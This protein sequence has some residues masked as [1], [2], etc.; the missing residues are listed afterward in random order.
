MRT[1]NPLPL[2][3]PPVPSTTKGTDIMNQMLLQQYQ[4][5]PLLKQYISAY[6]EEMD[7]LFEETEKV[8]LGRFL[9]YAEGTQLDIIGYILDEERNIS[10]PTL[11]FGFQDGTN[12]TRPP[13]VE[14]PSFADESAPA[15]GGVFRSEGQSGSENY[16]LSDNE[17]RRLLSAKAIISTSDVCS[18]NQAYYAITVLLGRVPLVMRFLPLTTAR[19]VELELD[20]NDTTAADEALIL[21][22]SKY[23]I[24]LGTTIQISRI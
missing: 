2:T 11:F 24:P 23:I 4:N 17:F 7:L 10:L 9:Q 16:A 13:N 22:F 18:I 14:D 1:D 20:V 15:V 21:Y 5:S 8:Y 19:N 6:V 3:A 12:S